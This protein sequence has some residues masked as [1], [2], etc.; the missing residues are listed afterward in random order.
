MEFRR[1]RAVATATPAGVCKPRRDERSNAIGEGLLP[2]APSDPRRNAWVQFHK[3][4]QPR[5]QRAAAQ[6]SAW[7]KLGLDSGYSSFRPTNEEAAHLFCH[8]PER[9]LAPNPREL[10]SLLR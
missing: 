7:S 9:L 4:I 6:P 3:C 5:R 1:V 8:Q 10:R 2:S